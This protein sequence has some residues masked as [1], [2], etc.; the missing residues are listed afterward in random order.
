[1]SVKMAINERKVDNVI[2]NSLSKASVIICF[3]KAQRISWLDAASLAKSAEYLVYS[4]THM[5]K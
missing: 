5:H 1:M 4:D 3:L 2:H